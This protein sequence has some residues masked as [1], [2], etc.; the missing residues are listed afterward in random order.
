MFKNYLTHS[1]VVRFH[2]TCVMLE[3]PRH[4]KSRVVRSSEQLLDQ[5]NQAV[6]AEDVKREAAFLCAA[7]LCLRDALETLHSNGIRIPELDKDG[8]L[9]Q[10]RLEDLCV[11][12]A[13][14]DGGQLR[15]LA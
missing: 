6:K 9:L 5:M 2:Q 14:S 7:L 15:M 8:A 13:A 4:V 10:K 12:A 1:F 11:K 3:I